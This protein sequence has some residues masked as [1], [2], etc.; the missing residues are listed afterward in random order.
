MRTTVVFLELTE[1]GEP[2]RLAITATCDVCEQ[3]FE[4]VG[5]EGPGTKLSEDRRELGLTITAA[6][7]WRVM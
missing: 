7:T 4:F 6:A 2:R 3:P 5:I 1:P